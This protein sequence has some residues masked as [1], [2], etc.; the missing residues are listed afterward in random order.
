MNN[1]YLNKKKFLNYSK[2]STKTNIFF[3]PTLI[4]TRNQKIS[5]DLMKSSWSLS[6]IKY[7]VQVNLFTII[8]DSNKEIFKHDVAAIIKILKENRLVVKDINLL[9]Q[10]LQANLF[11]ITLIKNLNTEHPY[12]KK[13]I[14]HY[15]KNC[16]FLASE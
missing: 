10:F 7:Y 4:F 16:E 3:L 14:L 6:F 11:L 8:K 5:W 15:F 13:V 2:G 9:L 1:I 12:C